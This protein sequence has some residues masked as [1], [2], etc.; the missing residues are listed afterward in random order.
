MVLASFALTLE[1]LEADH[2]VL[3]ITQAHL[4]HLTLGAACFYAEDQLVWH[5]RDVRYGR[6]RSQLG[7]P[8]VSSHLE[9]KISFC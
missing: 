1:R 3:F 9:T 4:A 5:E 2:P 7:G 6:L 8:L